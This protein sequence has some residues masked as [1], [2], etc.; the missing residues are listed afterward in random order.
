MKKKIF[1]ALSIGLL[2]VSG[3][4]LAATIKGLYPGCVE[5]EYLNASSNSDSLRKLME[6][7]KCTVV[8]KGEE[9]VM[10]DAGI[11]T[12]KILYK[13]FTLYVPSEAVR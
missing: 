10:I 2:V 8:Q 12:S 6:A 4:T 9:F 3:P 13:G 5:K 1:L 11:F 7:G